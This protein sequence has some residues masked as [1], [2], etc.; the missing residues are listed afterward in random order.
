[1]KRGRLPL[2]A[3]RSFEAAG[4][5]LSFS[6]AAEELFVSQAAISRQIRDLEALIG[7]PLFERRHRRV[8]LTSEGARLLEQLT[9]SFDEIDRRLTEIVAAPVQWIV[10]VSAEP[11]FGKAWLVPRLN[12]FSMQRPDVDVSVDVNGALVE[13]RSHEAELAIRYSMTRTSWPRVQSE[14]LVD[15]AVMPVLSPALLASGP[16]LMR[17]DDLR[18]Y[19]LLHEEN[20]KAWS[21][22]FEAA[23]A[24]DFAPNR[25]PIF[26]DTALA[27]QAAMLGHGVALGDTLLNRE[28][29]RSGRLIQPFPIEVPYGGYWLVAPDFKKLSEPA[30]AFAAWI[31]EEIKNGPLGDR[32]AGA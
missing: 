29:L 20:R 11:S 5:L 14:H 16:P 21:L 30:L 13:F 10:R 3:L 23:G 19:A 1:M 31:K 27:S 4:R 24:S 15:V 7:R 9:T 17:P 28:D 6:R 25:G 22:W 2:T 12:L 32:P 8:E 26:P 18:H